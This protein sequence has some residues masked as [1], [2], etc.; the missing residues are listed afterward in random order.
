MQQTTW[1]GKAISPE[2]PFGASIVV[3]RKS[4][5]G[6]DFLLLHRAHKGPDFEGDWAWT[7][8]AG[9]RLPK[10][11]LQECALRELREETGL[12]LEVQKTN[13]GTKDWAVFMAEAATDAQVIIDR[14]HDRFKWMDF[15]KATKYCKPE[16][17][18]SQIHQVAETL[19]SREEN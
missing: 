11:G 2:P 6:I 19:L 9:A 13:F 12:E 5:S 14:E 1:D 8:P 4:V 15:A 17:V 7:P 3:Y 16:N 10:E 18:A